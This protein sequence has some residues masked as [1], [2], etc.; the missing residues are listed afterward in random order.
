[1]DGQPTLLHHQRYQELGH[2]LLRAG[3]A[4]VP[5]HDKQFHLLAP[6]QIL[7]AA[8]QVHQLHLAGSQHIVKA[9]SLAQLLQVHLLQGPAAASGLPPGLHQP[10]HLV[11]GAAAAGAGAA[12]REDAEA[13]VAD[14]LGLDLLGFRVGG[15]VLVA[16]L[17]DR[18]Q[19]HALAGALDA[20]PA[21][22]QQGLEGGHAGPDDLVV[23]LDGEQLAQQLAVGLPVDP[24]LLVV[25]GQLH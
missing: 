24:L 11:G 20:G 14:L 17:V 13:Q 22:L 7:A 25:Q 9:H 12:S 3:E 2:R 23:V 1:M 5:Q 19:E 4:A 18:G 10:Q 8:V 15:V 21:L 6:S 16:D